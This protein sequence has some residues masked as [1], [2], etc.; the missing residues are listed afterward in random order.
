MSNAATDSGNTFRYDSSTGTYIFNMATSGLS[1]G[2]W[3]LRIDTHDGA[4]HTV[5][6][7]LK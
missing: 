2:T 3:Q 7:S 6:I 1:T 4:D 5:N